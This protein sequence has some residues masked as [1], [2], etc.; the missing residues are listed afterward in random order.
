MQFMPTSLVTTNFKFH[1]K[2]KKN[3]FTQIERRTSI[4]KR[5]I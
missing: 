4:H 5:K 2:K 3:F 1:L